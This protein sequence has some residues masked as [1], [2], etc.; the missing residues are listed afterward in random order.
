MWIYGRSLRKDS[1]LL[2][3]EDRLESYFRAITTMCSIFKAFLHMLSV[4]LGHLNT[5]KIGNWFFSKLVQV[6]LGNTC[7][8]KIQGGETFPFVVPSL[9][10]LPGVQNAT[11]TQ[12]REI[13]FI[14]V[15]QR[16][17][18]QVVAPLHTLQHI[19][20]SNRNGLY[21]NN[22]LYISLYIYIYMIGDVIFTSYLSLYLCSTSYLLRWSSSYTEILFLEGY[23]IVLISSKVI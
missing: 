1:S 21:T 15:L 14:A 17:G 6:K 11:D 16:N 23:F 4:D 8:P 12:S 19:A 20:S 22:K 18:C 2:Y 5:Y 10:S 3:S 13:C 9:S 7:W